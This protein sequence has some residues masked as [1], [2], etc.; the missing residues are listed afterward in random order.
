[1]IRKI[2]EKIFQKKKENKII[3]IYSNEES[4]KFPKE[5]HWATKTTGKSHYAVLADGVTRYLLRHATDD[6]NDPKI[7]AKQLK[8]YPNPS[9]A[10]MAAEKFC[11]ASMKELL[12]HSS[13]KDTFIKANNE[14]LKFSF[15][16]NPEPNL[17]ENDYWGCVASIFKVENKSLY[18]G[19]ICDC[20]I[21]VW[22]KNGK[23]KFQ[24]I[25][26][27]AQTANLMY[28][29]FKPYFGKVVKSATSFTGR[30]ILR[31]LFQNRLTSPRGDVTK[32]F[33]V[34]NGD[35]NAMDYVRTGSLALE[36]GDTVAAYSDGLTHC[37]NTEECSQIIK[38]M[39]YRKLKKFCDKKTHNEGSIVLVRV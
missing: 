24:T 1:M 25:D 18:W 8:D 37:I 36:N 30:V 32:G 39:D 21:T 4:N 5:D 23:I 35:R 14:L 19:F 13:I 10:K 31:G 26:E 7:R 12:D 11:K 22:D 29:I 15:K 2:R 16:H 3:K 6:M 27:G 20:G 38:E 17:L 33:G 9:P 34:I 28:K